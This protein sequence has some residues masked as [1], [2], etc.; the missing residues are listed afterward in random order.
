MIVLGDVSGIQRYLFDVAE[1]GGGQARRLRARSF[2]VQALVECAALRVLDSMNWSPPAAHFL[3]SGAGKFILRGSGDPD[4]I[5][6]AFEELNRELLHESFGELRLA[7]GI[8][9]GGSDVADYRQAQVG[10]QRAKAAPWK[11]TKEWEPGRLVLRP[12]NTPCPLCRR[13]PA[14]EDE[15]D[16][17][18]PSP[19]ERRCE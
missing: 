15:T 3:F 6:R 11:P 13:A 16:P 19:M 10:L 1:T 9:I 12:L 5:D 7:L 2:L 17:D 18:I 8:G 14:T 4:G